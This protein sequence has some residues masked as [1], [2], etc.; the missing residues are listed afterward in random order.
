M[1][2]KQL[3][4]YKQHNE[5]LSQFIVRLSAFYEGFSDQI[6]AELRILRGHLSGTPN[7]T[8][9]AISITKLNSAIQNQD[10]TLKKYASDATSALE[11]AMKMLQKIVYENE[12]LKK[13]VTNQLIAL[14]QPIGDIFSLYSL[15]QRALDLHRIA[16]ANEI[17]NHNVVAEE[18]GASKTK[19][20]LYKSILEEL[21]Q[22]IASYA[23]KKPTDKQLTHIKQRLSDGMTEDQLL[24]SCIVILRMIVQDAMAEASI[25]GKVIQSLHNSL[26]K[27]GSDIQ[28]SIEGSRHQYEQRQAGRAQ[29]QQQIE[30]MEDAVSQSH[31]LED[32]KEQTQFCVNT[33]ADTL[34]QQFKNDAQGQTSLVNL[35]SSMQSR[36][37]KLQKQTL[38]YK[39]KLTEQ[40]MLSQTDPLTG[41]PNRQAYDD[42]LSKAYQRWQDNKQQLT[43]AIIDIDHFKTIN[44]RFGHT[45]GDKTLQVVSNQLKQLLSDGM[46]MARWGGE[47]FTILVS[48]MA[49]Q[50]VRSMLENIRATLA[51]LPFKFKQEKITITASI[52]ATNF[53]NGDTPETVFDRADSY[54]YK[55]KNSGRNRVITD[56]DINE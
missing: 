18:P 14:N 6:D 30:V 28:L 46:F 52:G 20:S 24:K 5:L 25:T 22:L 38:L 55:A 51:S 48:D 17:S 8:L 19:D 42:K 27:I 31:T 56:Q 10:L 2:E 43:V 47:E 50:Q 21:N 26:D 4:T 3:K 23:Q 13:Q 40:L 53:K 34:S 11:N 12:E 36:I 7:F 49:P 41:L 35:L 33:I 9:A 16:L 32:L 37:D 1:V 29:L 15:F 54:L 39:K 45:A 44:D